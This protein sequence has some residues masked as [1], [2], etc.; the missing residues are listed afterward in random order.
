MTVLTIYTNKFDSRESVFG[1]GMSGKV[2]LEEANGN[3]E[4]GQEFRTIDE[5]LD[6]CEN[7]KTKID[8]IEFMY[9]SN[10][11]TQKFAKFGTSKEW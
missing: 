5:A 9:L 10:D 1:T 7:K 4:S 11:G 2:F 3:S 6:F 8:G